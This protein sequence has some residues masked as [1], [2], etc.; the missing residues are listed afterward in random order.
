MFTQPKIIDICIYIVNRLNSLICIKKSDFFSKKVSR[1][2]PYNYTEAE[3][4]IQPKLFP[5]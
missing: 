2:M 1:M 5:V 3:M 4:S